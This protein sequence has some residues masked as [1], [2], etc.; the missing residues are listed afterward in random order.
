MSCGIK[1]SHRVA[2]VVTLARINANPGRTAT[3]T[4]TLPEARSPSVM[5]SWPDGYLQT[6]CDLSGLL[7]IA[8]CNQT[9]WMPGT[10]KSRF[11][12]V[13][14]R[15][16]TVPEL[17]GVVPF[18]ARDI[19]TEWGLASGALEGVPYAQLLPPRMASL[20][21]LRRAMQSAIAWWLDAPGQRVKH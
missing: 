12:L 5:V 20:R 4:K 21:Q 9:T 10:L 6:E 17:R 2:G 8:T 3:S 15:R 11:R 18:V 1:L 14:V 19:E 13:D 7:Y 16:P